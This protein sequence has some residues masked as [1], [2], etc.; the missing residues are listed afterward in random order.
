MEVGRRRDDLVGCQL[1]EVRGPVLVLVEWWRLD[2]D[3]ER[4][5]EL[6]DCSPFDDDRRLALTYLDL[7]FTQS[8]RVE[9]FNAVAAKSHLFWLI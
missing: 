2:F 1:W 6:L 9:L 8:R 3:A 7:R 4:G 5:Q